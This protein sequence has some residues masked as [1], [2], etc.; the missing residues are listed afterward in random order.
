MAPRLLIKIETLYA[1][2][3]RF[4]WAESASSRWRVESDCPVSNHG[5][6]RIANGLS[7]SDINPDSYEDFI[8]TD[9]SINPGNSGRA[10]VNLRG[11]LIGI[12]A[13]ILSRSG[14]NIGFA[15]PI[16]MAQSVMDQWCNDARERQ[17]RHVWL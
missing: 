11:E 10:L 3:R 15:I 2:V 6:K 13:A 9:A 14:S 17:H 1:K 16:K 12:N 8:Q 4:R 7:R 5:S